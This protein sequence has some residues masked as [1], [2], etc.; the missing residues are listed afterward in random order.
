MRPFL[1]LPTKHLII[2]TQ[3][4]CFLYITISC[5]PP[6]GGQLTKATHSFSLLT[7][8][9]TKPSGPTSSWRTPFHESTDLSSAH[10]CLGA[11][12]VASFN[13]PRSSQRHFSSRCTRDSFPKIRP[14][15]ENGQLQRVTGCS[16]RHWHR[17][18]RTCCF[19]RCS[20]TC[21]R[22]TN[23]TDET[24]VEGESSSQPSLTARRYCRGQN[25]IAVKVH[26]GAIPHKLSCMIKEDRFISFYCDRRFEGYLSQPRFH[27]RPQEFHNCMNL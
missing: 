8:T 10:S 6:P 19:A 9:A 17:L 12:Q 22:I 13:L 2:P 1:S 27:Q 14:R 7:R 4:K 21:D 18:R 25:Q 20:W 16:V 23:V 26:P 5:P 3:P 11:H 15:T 24:G